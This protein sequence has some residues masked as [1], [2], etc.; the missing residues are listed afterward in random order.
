MKL[1]HKTQELISGY[2]D[3]ELTQQQNQLVRVHLETCVNC[4][5]VYQ[6]LKAIKESIS[7]LEYPECEEQK[8]EKILQD[9]TAKKISIVGWVLL[10]I[11]LA[12]L[13][14]YH[15]YTVF[16]VGSFSLFSMKTLILL[17]EAG[18]L[19]LFISV[20]RQRLIARKTDKYRNVKL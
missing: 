19:L 12:I 20:L 1:C 4:Q 5:A 17:I 3:N 18:A 13:F 7:G 14:I 2:L 8:M 16:T 15:L 10:I 9:P 11:P 6:D